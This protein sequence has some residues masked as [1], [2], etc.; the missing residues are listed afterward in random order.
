MTFTGS[1]IKRITN[2][3]MLLRGTAF[4]YIG[5][6]IILPIL[7]MMVRSLQGGAAVLWADI[8]LP[9]A[10]YSLKLTIITAFIMVL[11]NIVTG[12]ATAWV[13]VRYRFP[14][15]KIM[16]A[17]IDLP[18]AMPTIVAGI[19][20]VAL[21]GPRSVIGSFLQGYNIEVMFNTPGIILALL[22]VTFPFV[23]RAV[24]PVLI[25]LDQ[26]MEEAAKTMGASS[27]TIFFRI[28]LPSLLPSI[29]TGAALSFSRALG[30]FG[31]IIMV[32]GNIP[33]MTQVSSVYI[34]GEIESYNP[35]GALGLSVVLLLFSFAILLL[36]NFIQYWNRRHENK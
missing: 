11:I 9:Q 24:Q 15:K 7:A 8:T 2:A 23:V 21:Y 20:L 36:L 32:A 17:L 3:D 31:S 14:G 18:F 34:Y 4:G 29:L 25:E 1:P 5:L 19:M 16:D 35:Q 30:E 10:L 28:V 33:F 12:T 27:L 6:L 22:F 13:L 26:D